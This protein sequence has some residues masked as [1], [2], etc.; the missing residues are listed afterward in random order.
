[1]PPRIRGASMQCRQ[2]RGENPAEAKFCLHCG[3]PQALRCASCSQELPAGARFCLA[4]GEPVGGAVGSAVGAAVGAAAGK[5]IEAPSGASGAPSVTASPR[6]RATASAPAT[7]L[8]ATLGAGRYQV[9]SFLGEGARKR[10]Y[11]ARDTSLSSDVAVAV[12]KTEGLDADGLIRVRREAQAMGRLR[13]H[14]NIVPVF[15]IGQDGA[16]PYIVSQL[17]EG[18]SVA[19]RLHEVEAHRLPIEEAVRIASEIA[20]ALEHA[21]RLGIV[22][23]DLKPGNVWLARDGTAKLGDFGLA[24]ALDQSR[25]T[26]EGMLVGT[27]AYMPPEQAMGRTPDARSDL[28]ALGAM[29][30]EMVAGRPPFLGDDAVT[31]ISQHVST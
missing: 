18:G 17:L 24:V 8:P 13:D 30:Y 31:V 15:D 5:Q 3:V 6:A 10:V 7:P 1:M 16:Q 4:C 14:P 19:D 21:H 22:H 25:L 9:K 20:G 29:L 23:R 26:Q 11:L 28:Y 2:C 27:V 12:V